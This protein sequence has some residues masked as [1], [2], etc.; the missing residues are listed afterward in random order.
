MVNRIINRST[1]LSLDRFGFELN[2][3]WTKT[4]L[5]WYLYNLFLVHFPHF[6]CVS[7]MMYFS[8]YSV[9]VLALRLIQFVLKIFDQTRLIMNLFFQML[10]YH[11]LGFH[12]IDDYIL[13]FKLLLEILNHNIFHLLS[14]VELLLQI[15]GI[16]LLRR[17]RF[18][19]FLLMFY[20]VS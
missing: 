12:I 2:G 6:S 14:I 17:L 7:P 10:V 1:S 20:H 4:I 19:E 3:V 9:A 16:F 15:L 5:P 18:D 13:I 8:N 11:K